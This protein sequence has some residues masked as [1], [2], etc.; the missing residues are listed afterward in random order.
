MFVECSVIFK[1]HIGN[2]LTGLS[3]RYLPAIGRFLIVVTFLEDALRIIT[4]WSDQLL[5]LHDYRHSMPCLSAIGTKL[6]DFSSS[7][8]W[9]Y[10]PLPHNKRSRHVFMFDPR[11]CA[12]ILRLRSCWI[13]RCRR[14]T[15]AWVWIDLR[16]ELLP[17]QPV[18]HGWTIDGTFRLVDPQIKGLRW[19][20]TT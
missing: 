18:C 19:S 5:Y 11:Y 6:T 9:A 17:P 20:P 4:Q 1:G 13:N 8:I 10:P 12:K 3:S 15:S 7:S 2:E 16:S 14:H